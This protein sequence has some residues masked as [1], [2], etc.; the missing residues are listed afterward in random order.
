[1]LL[2]I[3]SGEVLLFVVLLIIFI[4]WL[5]L[6]KPVVVPDVLVATDKSSYFREESVQIAGTLTI[7]GN[8]LV[9]QT[10]GLSVK[11][12]TGDAYSLPQVQTDAQG[13][14]ASS[15]DIPM[16][17]I[18]GS[19]DLIVASVGVIGTATFTPRSQ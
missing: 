7:N 12:P 1:M 11:P 13:A 4:I 19:Y 14:Y 2:G 16:D 17:A 5:I 8:P 9:G 10:V 18:E 15:W 3:V 6:G